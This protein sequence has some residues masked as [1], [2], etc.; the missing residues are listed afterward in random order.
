MKQRTTVI[1]YVLSVYVILQFLWWGYHLIEL[2][3]ELSTESSPVNKRI[4]MILGEGAVFLLILFFGIWQI[5]RAIRKDLR[6]SK[7]QNNFLLSVTH[8]LKT[9]LAANKL[10]IQ[11]VKKRTFSKEQQDQILLKAI[12]ENDRLERMIDNMLNA[13]RLENNVLKPSKEQVNL[14]QLAAN[15]VER[16]QQ[17]AP[18]ATFG[19]NVDATLEISADRLMIEMILDNLVENA[20]KYA[21]NT[22]EITL[23]A[24]ASGTG[25]QF[26]VKDNGP[27]V[28]VAERR[29]I[30]QKFY[31]SGNED[32]RTQKGSGLGLYIVSEFVKLHQGVIVYTP[33][34]PNGADFQVTL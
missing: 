15:V 29:E 7:R 26:G 33:N 23:Y 5:R 20:L 13:T 28:E 9:P 10:Y 3:R 18:S 16:F 25:I 4:A 19:V 11:T 1:F 32:T 8:E 17:L 12:E 30:F 31:R 2:T 21:G 27:G 6:L 22:A 24:H 14:S 34:T